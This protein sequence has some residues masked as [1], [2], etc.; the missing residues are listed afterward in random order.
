VKFGKGELEK[1]EKVLTALQKK[2]LSAELTRA[3]HWQTLKAF[4]KEQTKAANKIPLEMFGAHP[5]NKAVV[6]LPK[7][8]KG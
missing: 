3:I 6:K 8:P 5:F 7:P 2:K 4:V 1:A